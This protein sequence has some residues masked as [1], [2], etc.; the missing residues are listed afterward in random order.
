MGYESYLRKQRIWP[1]VR[2]TNRPE[3]IVIRRRAD[4]SKVTAHERIQLSISLGLHKMF[5]VCCSK[6]CQFES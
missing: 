1:Q 6:N 5:L 2:A 4:I 3:S